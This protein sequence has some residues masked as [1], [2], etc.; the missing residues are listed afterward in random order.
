MT[1]GVVIA[2]AEGSLRAH[3]IRLGDLP[4]LVA[5]GRPSAFM[6]VGILVLV[7]TPITR[8]LALIVAFAGDRD[9]RFAAIAGAVAALL[10][11]GVFLGRL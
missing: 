5:G 9:P 1:I 11:L 3:S 2:F 8:V 10:A 6:A 4:G 7:A